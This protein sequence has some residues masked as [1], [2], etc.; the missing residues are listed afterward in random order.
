M[1]KRLVFPERAWFVFWIAA[2]A[3]VALLIFLFSAQTA[4]E[5]D[6]ISRG[7]LRRLLLSGIQRNGCGLP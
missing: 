5:S 4:P 7:L 2:S 3:A 6:Q 1:T